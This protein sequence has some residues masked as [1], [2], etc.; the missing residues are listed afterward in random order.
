MATGHHYTFEKP[1]L[2]LGDGKLVI[3]SSLHGSRDGVP[4]I[5]DPR[6]DTLTQGPVTANCYAV[7][8]YTGC[9]LRAGSANPR[10]YR[11]LELLETGSSHGLSKM[12]EHGHGRYRRRGKKALAS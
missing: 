10:R 11:T 4:Q 7:G 5:Y 1:L 9:L 3:W 6:T 8:A 2:V 12:I